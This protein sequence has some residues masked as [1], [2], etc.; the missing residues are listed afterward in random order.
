MEE[1]QGWVQI[2]FHNDLSFIKQRFLWVREAFKSFLTQKI[3]EA[4]H[5]KNKWNVRKYFLHLRNR[6]S[7]LW[8]KQIP[9]LSE[10]KL[11]KGQFW[12][13]CVQQKCIYCLALRTGPDF[14]VR[15]YGLLLEHKIDT[16]YLQETA[17]K[18]TD[19]LGVRSLKIFTPD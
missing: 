8:K 14:L 12:N 11:T 16:I 3:R 7:G 9:I 6:T 10:R 13:S 5:F 4:K 17:P 15:V 19:K 2:H 18:S 1:T